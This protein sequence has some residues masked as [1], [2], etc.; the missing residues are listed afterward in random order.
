MLKTQ[1]V[2]SNYVKNVYEVMKS[3]QFVYNSVDRVWN[4]CSLYDPLARVQDFKSAV[5]RR[6]TNALRLQ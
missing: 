2:T 1:F 6:F 3:V 4:R 5:F